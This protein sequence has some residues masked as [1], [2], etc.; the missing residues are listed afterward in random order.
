MIL[1]IVCGVAAAFWQDCGYVFSR[2]YVKRFAAPV[3]LLL[4]TQLLMGAAGVVIMP[5]V[6]KC[7]F[8]GNWGF[9]IPLLGSAFGSLF[10]Q[11]FFFKTEEHVSPARIASLMGLRVV[12][13]AAVSGLF[14]SEHYDS[15]QICGIV[16]AALSA[17]VI[18]Y[19]GKGRIATR[20]MGWFALTLGSYCISDLSVKYMIDRIA[21]G[22]F[23]TS[24][25]LGMSLVN[26]L[27]MTVTL[28]WAIHARLTPAE[29]KP[30]LPFAG[31]WLVKQILLYSCYALIGPVFG[32][33][34]MSLRGP[35][36]IVLTLTLLR[37]GVKKLD[38]ASG[39]AV[40]VRRGVAT[41]MMVAAIAL[42]S[43]HDL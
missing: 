4:A 12:V 6:W 11:L 10:G 33:V 26:I 25:L 34:I 30:T 38:G 14:L 39:T 5:F 36:A 24:A 23:F 28:P 8:W 13:L 43:L 29:L 42:Y 16:L 2:L 7:G 18:N 41:L 17:L 9:V 19:S 37:L 20:G 21:T 40:W 15:R 27:L 22:N 32:N 3:K 31:S 1:G 35:I